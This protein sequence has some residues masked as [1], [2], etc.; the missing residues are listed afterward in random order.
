MA[1]FYNKTIS[2]EEAIKRSNDIAE[3]HKKLRKSFVVNCWHTNNKGESDAMWR[4][5]LKTNEGV[6][7]QS[8]VECC[9][10]LNRVDTNN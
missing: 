4:L 6:A 1:A 2:E 8:T 10:V 9:L 3:L 7:I 5:Y